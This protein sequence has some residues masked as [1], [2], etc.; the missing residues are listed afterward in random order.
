MAT[1][2]LSRRIIAAAV[3]AASL[4]GCAHNTEQAYAA[5]QAQIAREKAEGTYPIRQDD[6]PP[7]APLLSNAPSPQQEFIENLRREM[8]RWGATHYPQEQLDSYS[9]ADQAECRA[10]GNSAFGDLSTKTSVMWDC[11]RA[12]WYRTHPAKKS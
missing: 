1:H 12:K 4:G 9:Q 8:P 5:A 10:Q 3:I 7:P 11:L 2:T 6:Y